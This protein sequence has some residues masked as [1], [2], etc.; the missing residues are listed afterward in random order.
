MKIRSTK[1]DSYFLK[2]KNP[3]ISFLI[4][5]DTIFT[6]AAGLLGPIFAF[7]IVDFIQGGSVAVAGLAATIYLFTKSVFQIPIAYLIDRIRG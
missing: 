5:S 7:F 4:I 3:V 2:N 1:L 6:G